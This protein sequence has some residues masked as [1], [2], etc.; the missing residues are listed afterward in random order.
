MANK[1]RQKYIWDYT[2]IGGFQPN[3]EQEV[4]QERWNEANAEYEIKA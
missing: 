2:Q 3:I 1:R 4:Y